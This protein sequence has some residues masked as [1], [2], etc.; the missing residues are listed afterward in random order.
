MLKNL[1]F[2]VQIF[3]KDAEFFHKN[4]PFPYFVLLTA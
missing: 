3:K 4:S 2:F 1:C